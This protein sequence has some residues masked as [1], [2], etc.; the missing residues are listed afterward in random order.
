[1]LPKNEFEKSFSGKFL[2]WAIFYGRY[3][4]ILTEIVV[5][6]AF[7]LRFRVDADLANV[8]DSIAGKKSI[9]YTNLK[10]EDQF[11]AV[12]TR[13]RE[14]GKVVSNRSYTQTLD[15]VINKI[16]DGVKITTLTVNGSDFLF[17]ATADQ[18]SFNALVQ[19]MLSTK[20]FNNVS[21]SNIS[22]DSTNTVKFSLKANY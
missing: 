8:N 3:V 11:K 16:P 17:T 20:E 15:R 2:N 9:I 7:F 22:Y 19:N 14:A 12:Q 21:L 4:V 10:F 13:V 1:M 5:I 18:T 6:V